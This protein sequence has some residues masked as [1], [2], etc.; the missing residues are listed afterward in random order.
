MTVEL[1]DRPILE[2][3]TRYRGYFR[4]NRLLGDAWVKIITQS[5]AYPYVL[6]AQ[7]LQKGSNEFMLTPL[8][9]TK[10]SIEISCDGEVDITD[11]HLTKCKTLYGGKNK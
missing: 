10:V 6:H 3:Y 11:W 2:A 9:T 4:I 5:Y 7:K 8:A 1:N